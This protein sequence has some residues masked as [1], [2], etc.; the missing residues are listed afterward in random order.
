MAHYITPKEFAKDLAFY[1]FSKTTDVAFDGDFTLHIFASSRY[2]LY[3]NGKYICE[4]PCRGD[5]ETRYFDEV[6]AFLSKG[7]NQITLKVLHQTDKF[8]TV[9]KTLKPCVLFEAVSENQTIKSDKSWHCFLIENH[10]PIYN[11]SS[12]L[13]PCEE[14]TALPKRKEIELEEAF[15]FENRDFDFSENCSYNQFGIALFTPLEKRPLPMIYPSE[16]ISFS[17][18]KSGDDFIELDAGK[19]TTARVCF[20]FAANADIKIIYSEC[21]SFDDG[22]RKRDDLSGKLDGYYDLIHTAKN[23]F[24]YETYWFRAFRFIRIETKNPKQVLKSIK[25]YRISYPLEIEASFNCSD[26]ALNK[27]MPIS[28]NTLLCCMHEIF[29][30]CPHYEQQQY[31]MDSAIECAVLRKLSSDTKM[32]KKCITDFAESQHKNGLL[33][34]NYPS[35]YTQIIP[36]FSIFWIDLL[37]DYLNYSAD[38]EFVKAFTGVMDRI[39]LFFDDT[40]K[41]HGGVTVSPYWDFVDWVPGWTHG[42]LPLE[43]DEINTIYSLYYAYGLKCAAEICEKVGRLGLAAEYKERLFALKDAINERCFDEAKGLYRNGEKTATYSAHTIVWAILSEVVP[44][45]K[46]RALAAHLFDEDISKCT[47]S[48]NFY[49][50]RALEKCGMYNKAYDFFDGWKKM[51]DL[52][53]TTWCENPDDPRSECHAWSCAPAH[54]FLSCYLGVKHTFDESITISP[55]IGNL[56]FARGTVMTRHGAVCV[57][58]KINENRF[59]ISI[60]APDKITKKLLLPNGEERIFTDKSAAFECEI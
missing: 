30:D 50:F 39:L 37:K 55:F 1:E 35:C 56:S 45:D 24:H 14:I 22:K 5:S 29:V 44:K 52:N 38:T 7:E 13:P 60:N 40:V 27:M 53:C 49:L 59:K 8:M 16:E 34:A 2:I 31:I 17:A 43:D 54:E 32:I 18:V 58:W 51:L 28:I 15:F 25:A 36:G 19:Y 10:K 11:H 48:M 23:D 33:S 6:T 57:D 9:F 42:I 21:Y 41:K 4:G 20:D 26:E 47:F 12:F 46:E 3:I